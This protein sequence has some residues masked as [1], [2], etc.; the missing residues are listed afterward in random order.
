MQQR[1]RPGRPRPCRRAPARPPATG[2]D[3]RR[4]AG[5]AGRR[6]GNRRRRLPA[7][8]HPGA[9]PGQGLTRPAFGAGCMRVTAIDDTGT[10]N[11]NAIK[12]EAVSMGAMDCIGLQ[13]E[14]R[15][16]QGPRPADRTEHAAVPHG[17]CARRQGNGGPAERRG[18]RCASSTGTVTQ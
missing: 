14:L 1:R 9:D 8:R 18:L 7:P 15:P 6:D 11:V 12:A 5:P 3:R 2:E 10:T 13:R 16:L 17:P 4:G